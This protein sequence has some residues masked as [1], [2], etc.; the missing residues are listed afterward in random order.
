MF[1]GAPRGA[2][3]NQVDRPVARHENVAW[4]PPGSWIEAWLGD[5]PEQ[6]E[7]CSAAFAFAFDGEGRMVLANVLKRGPDIPGGRVEPGETPEETAVREAAEETG[8]RIRLLGKVGHLRIEVP[9]PP[10]G[11]RYPTPV[12]LQPF[13]AAVVEAMGPVTMPHECGTPAWVDPREAAEDPRFRLHRELILAAVGM[14][15]ADEPPAP[16]IP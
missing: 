15:R 3:V 7:P 9:N 16:G 2:Q 1:I 13:Y 11:F 14:H 8:A 4:L 5:R 6:D 10:P 12:A